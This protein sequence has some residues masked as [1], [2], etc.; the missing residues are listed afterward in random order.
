[1]SSAFSRALRLGPGF[2]SRGF[3]ILC[4]LCVSLAFFAVLIASIIGYFT[5]HIDEY[6]K[7]IGE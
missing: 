4:D 2:S 6:Y 1:M 7:S 5:N 3:F